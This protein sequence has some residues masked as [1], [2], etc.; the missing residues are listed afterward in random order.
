VVNNLTANN[1]NIRSVDKNSLVN[2][3]EYYLNDKIQNEKNRI[4]KL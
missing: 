2:A 1:G 3:L 4:N